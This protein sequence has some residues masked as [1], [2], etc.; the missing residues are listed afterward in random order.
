MPT[1]FASVSS[2][3]LFTN[4]STYYGSIRRAD[5][6]TDLLSY[7]DTNNK[8]HLSTIFSTIEYTILSTIRFSIKNAVITTIR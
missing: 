8:T 4:S 3:L 2:A 7:K 6:I 1:I 5:S